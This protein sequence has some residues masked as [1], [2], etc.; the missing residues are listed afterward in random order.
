[1]PTIELNLY[2]IANISQLGLLLALITVLLLRRTD[3]DTSYTPYRRSKNCLTGMMLIVFA[4]LLA[5]LFINNFSTSNHADTI[6]DVILYTPA[7]IL[8]TWFCSWLISNNNNFKRRII[9][10]I[11]IWIV[12]LIVVAVTVNFPENVVAQVTF[13]FFLSFWGIFIAHLAYRIIISFRNVSMGMRNYYSSDAS[14]ALNQ[15]GWG[16]LTYTCYGIFAPVASLLSPDFNSIYIIVGNIAYIALTSAMLNHY[17]NYKTIDRV[18]RLHS[19]V[20]G[21]KEVSPNDFSQ[22]QW[23][24]S[25]WEAKHAYWKQDIT[26]DDM[27]NDIDRN[28]GTLA[29]AINITYKCSFYEHVNRLRIRDAQTMLVHNPDQPIDEIATTVGFKNAGELTKYFN[30]YANVTPT[31][32]RN[33]VLK[34]MQ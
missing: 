21:D 18:L 5:S 24:M 12:T 29:A 32:W 17:D 10:D 1:M 34:L 22:I 7:A 31:E 6:L 33:G 30:I 3:P 16:I 9:F 11:G 28:I 25:N 26:I 4:D 8:F 19:L 14:K 2:N 27:A 20:D 23:L 15:L 13:W